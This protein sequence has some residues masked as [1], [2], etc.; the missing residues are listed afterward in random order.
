VTYALLAANIG[1]YLTYGFEPGS[2]T[3]AMIFGTFGAVPAEI[4]RGQD[5]QAVFT[6]MFLHAGWMHLAGNMLFLYIF[7]DN[8]ED[9]L[10][11][12]PFAGSYLLGGVLA[13]LTHVAIAPA[14]RVPLVGASGAIAAVMGGYLLLFPKARVDI[15]FFF[16]VFIRIVPV[17]AWAVLCVWFGVQ[18]LNGAS[19]TTGGPVAHWA[20]VGGFVAGFVMTLP[21][22]LARG[23]PAFWRRTHMH[24][25]YPEARYSRSAIPQVGRRRR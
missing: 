21:W 16:I 13:T 19:L 24:P 17:P 14:S 2:R 25:P 5:L 8:M 4:L 20:H 15:F 3:A 22:W 6:S 18:L 11:H 7:G 23:G 12:V 10:G 1:I 9:Q